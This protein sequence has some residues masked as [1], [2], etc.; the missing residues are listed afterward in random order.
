MSKIIAQTVD[1]SFHDK[2]LLSHDFIIIKSQMYSGMYVRNEV[3]V[4]SRKNGK[5]HIIACVRS[6]GFGEDLDTSFYLNQEQ[7]EEVF[8]C[9]NHVIQEKSFKK[10]DNREDFTYSISNNELKVFIVNSGGLRFANG[11]ELKPTEEKFYEFKDFR[12]GY[13]LILRLI[14][15][16]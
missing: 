13:S 2:F 8:M 7:V 6:S 12:S 16:K 5:R 3:N 15:V 11:E 4:I 14:G 9:I 10:Y 1:S